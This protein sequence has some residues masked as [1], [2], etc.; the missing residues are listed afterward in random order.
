MILGLL[1]G[2]WSTHTVF[3]HCHNWQDLSIEDGLAFEKSSK[4]TWE[5]RL[6]GTGI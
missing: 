6:V 4:F 2:A 3:D 5:P 1:S